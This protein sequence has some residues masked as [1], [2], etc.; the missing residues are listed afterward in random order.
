M[1][2][3]VT[4]GTGFVGREMLWRLHEAGHT[5]RLVSRR[6]RTPELNQL[7]YRYRAELVEASGD[8][9]ASLA[10]AVQGCE[11]VIHLVGII[12]ESGPST[13]ERVHVDY[14]R[15][16]LAAAT[17]SG[18]SRFIHMSALG[19][20]PHA[21]ARYHQ[22]KWQA[23]E[24]VRNSGLAWTIFR[25][26][27]IYGREDGF[28]NMLAGIARW[29]PVVPIFGPGRNQLQPIAVEDVA[30]AFVAS[31]ENPAAIGQ[32][33]DLCGTEVFTMG[34]IWA[35]IL[36]VTRR[37]RWPLRIPM[38]LARAQAAALELGCAVIGRPS[39][40]TRDQLLMLG[41]DNTGDPQRAMADF[42][43]PHRSFV[44]EIAKY[45]K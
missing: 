44:A 25:P 3:L 32:T 24:L 33:Y 34:Q 40:L 2:V 1:K 16:I 7:A 23:E 31:V 38:G 41:E 11:A 36:R 22:T 15:A 8:V 26:S 13:F 19:T 20:R 5:I 18:V 4:G 28:V 45:L 39:P 43:L 10:T 12:S 35:A 9:P 14:T 21:R 27:V 6:S 29:S 42:S 37:K 17:A 30:K